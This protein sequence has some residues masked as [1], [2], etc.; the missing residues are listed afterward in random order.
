MINI[1]WRLKNYLSIFFILIFP[2]NCFADKVSCSAEITTEYNVGMSSAAYIML[3]ITA[4]HSFRT[5]WWLLLKCD[6][7]QENCFSLKL[8][9]GK[10]KTTF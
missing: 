2:L 4:K 7:N 9:S 6:P 1:N 8:G 3:N 5:S 10:S